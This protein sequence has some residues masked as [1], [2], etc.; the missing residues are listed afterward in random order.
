MT[1]V[2]NHLSWELIVADNN[3]KDNTR[4]EVEEFRLDSELNVRYAFEGYQKT[5]F[6]MN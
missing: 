4:D 5:D 6:Y 2:P 1:S 3:S